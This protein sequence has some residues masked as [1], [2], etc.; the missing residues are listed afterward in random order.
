MVSST[1]TRQTAR[2]SLRN[3]WLQAVAVTLI[4]CL[5]FIVIGFIPFLGEIVTFV[6][7][8][9]LILGFYVYHLKL[10]RGENPDVSLLFSGFNQFLQ[11]FVLYLL[12]SIFI[13]LWTL[14]LIIPGIIAS[15]RYSMAYFIMNDNPGMTAVEAIQTSKTMMEGHKADLFVLSLSFIGWILLAVLTLGIGFLWLI[16]YMATS[17]AAFYQNI[18]DDSYFSPNYSDGVPM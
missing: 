10:I 12:T 7:A 15:L 13:F 6:I 2:D 17:I 1:Q 16:P 8:G 14:L 11:T 4:Y 18:K 9:P 3:N 5:I